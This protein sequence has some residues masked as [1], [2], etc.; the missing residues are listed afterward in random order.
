MLDVH[1][2]IYICCIHNFTTMK[3]LPLSSK[4]NTFTTAAATLV[5]FGKIANSVMSEL[6][7]FLHSELAKLLSLTTNISHQ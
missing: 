3:T 2:L 7:N 6:M 5:Q 4:Q 1:V